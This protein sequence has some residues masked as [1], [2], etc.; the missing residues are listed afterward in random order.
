MSISTGRPR[1][2]SRRCLPPCPILPPWYWRCAGAGQ[3]SHRRENATTLC[4]GCR[5]GVYS[6]VGAEH[7]LEETAPSVALCGGVAEQIVAVHRV[8]PGD[9]D[10]SGWDILEAER[11]CRRVGGQGEVAVRGIDELRIGDLRTRIEALS[12]PLRQGVGV[13]RRGGSPD[14]ERRAV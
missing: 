1:L 4:C 14:V 13:V 11:V 3:N 12:L 10:L 7:T 6:A 5:L 9:A 2:R 8:I